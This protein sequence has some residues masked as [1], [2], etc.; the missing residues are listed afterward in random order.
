[1]FRERWLSERQKNYPGPS[2]CCE[3]HSKHPVTS[4]RC[5]ICHWGYSVQF[6]GV[7][8]C[9]RPVMEPNIINILDAEG[10]VETVLVAL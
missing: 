8:H 4:Y 5:Q 7:M 3:V 1:M 9:T 10:V 2:T 6:G